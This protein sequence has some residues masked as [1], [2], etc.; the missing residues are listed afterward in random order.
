MKGIILFFFKDALN[1]SQ[2]SSVYTA[3]NEKVIIV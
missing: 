2:Q 1:N 3:S